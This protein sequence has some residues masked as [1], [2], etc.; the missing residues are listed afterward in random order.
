MGPRMN[1]RR[2]AT[3]A[4]H[5]AE[6]CAK[7]PL[8]L[9]HWQTYQPRDISCNLRLLTLTDSFVPLGRTVVPVSGIEYLFILWEK[10]ISA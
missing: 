3:W 6:E 9:Y 5:S 10:L 1:E 8:K 7:T 2:M 4:Q